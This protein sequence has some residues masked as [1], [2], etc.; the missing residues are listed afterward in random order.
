[1]AHGKKKNKARAPVA[2]RAP[3]APAA[4]RNPKEPPCPCGCEIFIE[5]YA[6][7]VERLREWN[8]AWELSLRYH[9]KVVDG[10]MIYSLRKASAMNRTQMLAGVLDEVSPAA[11]GVH[12]ELTRLS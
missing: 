7:G 6:G 3:P 9:Y 5:D 11:T 4:R 12:K 2:P 8:K 10:E 1:M